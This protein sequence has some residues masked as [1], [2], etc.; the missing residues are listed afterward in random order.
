MAWLPC[1]VPLMPNQC[2]HRGM[3]GEAGRCLWYA[4]S[5]SGEA[6]AEAIERLHGVWPQRKQEGA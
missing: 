1:A 3:C 5:L 4:S 2:T 6:E